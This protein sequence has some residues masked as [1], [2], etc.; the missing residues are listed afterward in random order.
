MPRLKL[1]KDSREDARCV[2]ECLEGDVESFSVLVSKYQDSLYSIALRMTGDREEAGDIAQ[3]AFLK[4][5]ENLGAYDPRFPFRPWL[6]R[7]GTN[8][9]IDF[10]RKRGK[11][12]RMTF[13]EDAREAAAGAARGQSGFPDPEE[14]SI[15][16]DIAAAV[17]RALLELP[18][19]YRA[20]ILLHYMEELSFGE[21]GK[22]MGIPGNTAKTWAHR[23]RRILCETL[24]GVHVG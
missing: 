19:K 9:S 1:S 6:F 15:E 14:A 20:V 17:E 24:E 13:I 4:A 22:V 2:K 5:Y 12:Q 7:I 11:A 16:S 8:C 23:G 21:I 10:L 3:E 18:E